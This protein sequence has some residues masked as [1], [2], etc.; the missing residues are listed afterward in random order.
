MQRSRDELPIPRLVS[1]VVDG[2][3]LLTDESLFDACGVRIAFTGRAGGVSQGAYSTLNTATHVGDDA[4][5]AE[6]NRRRVL[7]AIGAQAC[8][9]I[10]P[11]Q[12]HGTNVV[13]VANAEEIERAQK[14]VEEGAD[15]VAVFEK[16]VAAM[17]FSAD[18]LLLSV[19]APSGDFVVAHAGWRGAVAHVAARAA[20]VLARESGLD[21]S[22]F[23]VY[24]GP[25]IRSECFEVG[26]EVAHAFEAE[27]G[28]GVLAD[29]RHVSL[30]DAVSADLVES[31]IDRARIADS[32]ICTVCNPE[33][34]FS[35]RASGGTCGRNAAIAVAVR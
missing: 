32:G 26:L 4:Q 34:Y 13:S 35:Y 5:D 25:H 28:S 12:V 10:A 1:R 30:A 20:E 31:G 17:L 14:R 2:I 22:G 24:I 9:L 11:N 15:A 3:D 8:T 16:G 29:E 7:S 21:P 23:N 33:R 18:C 19:V 6:E 27:F